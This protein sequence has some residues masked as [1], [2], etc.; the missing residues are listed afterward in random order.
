[1]VIESLQDLIKQEKVEEGKDVMIKTRIAINY[2]KILSNKMIL[3]KDW[4]VRFQV[5][6]RILTL[7]YCL[8]S[9]K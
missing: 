9:N 5:L 7:F 3:I 8:F 2:M 6:K 1:M 4:V